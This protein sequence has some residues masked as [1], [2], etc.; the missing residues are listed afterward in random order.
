MKK[1]IVAL[2]ASVLGLSTAAI[3]QQTPPQPSQ[4]TIII[5]GEEVPVTTVGAAGA[6]LIGLG[7]VLS[8]DDES[9]TTTTTTD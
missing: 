5:N 1:M 2:V 9:G 8:D 4:N 7:I 6:G 3:A